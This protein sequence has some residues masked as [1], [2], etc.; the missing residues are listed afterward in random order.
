VRDDLP[1]T[2]AKG[3]EALTP[4]EKDRL[5]WVGSFFRKPTPGR[6]MMRLIESRL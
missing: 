2:I 6:L 5:K 1:E 3:A 4:A